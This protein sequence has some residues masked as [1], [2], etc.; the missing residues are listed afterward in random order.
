MCV[1]AYIFYVFKKKKKPKLIKMAREGINRL[2]VTVL[3]KF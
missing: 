3:S 1:F 2:G